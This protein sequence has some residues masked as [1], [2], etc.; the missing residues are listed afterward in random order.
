MTDEPR[1][2]GLIDKYFV[3]QMVMIC[4]LFFLLYFTLIYLLKM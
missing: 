1:H 4:F 2:G 3:Y